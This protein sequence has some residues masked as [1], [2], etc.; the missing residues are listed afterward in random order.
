MST[1]KYV[2]IVDK[3]LPP[4]VIANLIKYANAE[5]FSPGLTIGDANPETVKSE[6]NAEVLGLYSHSNSLSNSHW[7]SLM[8]RTFKKAMQNY[9]RKWD[10]VGEPEI[11]DIQILKYVN[12]GF[13]TYHVD[14]NSKVPRTLSCI[15]LLNNDYEGG[16]L[17]FFDEVEKK[18]FC[19]ESKPGRVILWPSNF[20]FPHTVK[21]VTKGT[22]YSVVLW[23]L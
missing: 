21:P 17:C 15:I 12:K 13:Y 14:H 10:H 16:E 1:F 4:N 23:A 9:Q 8:A 20:C 3:L 18:E 2:E 7:A 11:Q 6:R 19:I 22:R 5:K